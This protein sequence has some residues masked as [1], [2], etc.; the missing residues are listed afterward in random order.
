[1]K[2]NA[3]LS[4]GRSESSDEC[5][6]PFY[7]VDPLIEYLSKDKIY[8]LPFDTDQ[9]AFTQTLKSL[10]YQYTNTHIDND[11]DFFTYEPKEWDILVSNPPFSKKNQILKRAYSFNKPFALLL[12]TNSINGKKRFELFENGIQLLTFDSRIDYHTRNN[13]INTTPRNHFAS[14]YFCRDLLPNDLIIKQ[15]NKYQ[16]P[17][18][19]MP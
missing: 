6:T 7:A 10:G 11:Q 13:L 8:W 4:S 14:S 12:P 16:K 2:N 3:Y 15:L 5:Y 18:I 19:P 17:L 9:S 1:M